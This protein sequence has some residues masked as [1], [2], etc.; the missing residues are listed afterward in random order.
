MKIEITQA[1]LIRKFMETMRLMNIYLNHFP[2]HERYALCARIRTTAYAVYDLIVEG[3]KRYH[4]KTT[5]TALDIAHEQLRMQV[6]LA[7]ELGYFGF[8]K[9]VADDNEGTEPKRYMAISRHIDELGK[10][11]GAW[12]SRSQEAGAW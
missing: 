6:F 8:T 12:I 4:K 2:K 5:L 3:M 11:I 7:H 10:M 1:P 9:C